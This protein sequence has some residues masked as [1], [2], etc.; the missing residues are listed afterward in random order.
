MER[1][2]KTS[3]SPIASKFA[4]LRTP[5]I[6]IFGVIL[7][8]AHLQNFDSPNFQQVR[9]IANHHFLGKSKVWT[10][11]TT[12]WR[13]SFFCFSPGSSHSR[14]T[15]FLRRWVVQQVRSIEIPTFL[16]RA[17]FKT[18]RFFLGFS[19]RAPLLIHFSVERTSKPIVFV[20]F[21]ASALYWENRDSHCSQW[22][23][24]QNQWMLWF[25]KARSIANPHLNG[26]HFKTMFVCGSSKRALLLINIS[27]ER[28]C[29]SLPSSSSCR[30]LE[31]SQ[32][33]FW[34][35]MTWAHGRSTFFKKLWRI[36]IFGRFSN[37]TRGWMRPEWSVGFRI[38]RSSESQR[39]QLFRASKQST[40]PTERSWHWEVWQISDITLS[41]E[42]FFWNWCTF[43]S[44]TPFFWQL[45]ELLI[46]YCCV[47]AFCHFFMSAMT[48]CIRSR[49]RSIVSW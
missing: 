8:G 1:T 49:K 38:P 31:W 32:P 13:L 37:W 28:T 6:D 27:I 4:L 40:L 44:G 47:L 20:V 2:C 12:F 3:I 41:S 23:A 33:L 14:D 36:T 46:D 45:L 10:L 35:I 42:P 17:H 18:D 5:R 7:N 9:P 24:L 11:W 26:A 39:L 30:S 48:F 22:S 16:N 25:W 43:S 19:K 21:E 29:R 15:D 34:S